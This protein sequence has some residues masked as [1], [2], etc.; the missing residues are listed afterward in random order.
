MWTRL[1]DGYAVEATQECHAVLRGMAFYEFED[2][3]LFSEENRMAF[4]KRSFSTRSFPFSCS[5]DLSFSCLETAASSTTFLTRG[6][7]R[8]V[9]PGYAG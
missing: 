9:N 6:K 5:S 2:F 3:R 1:S 8:L 7:S 4:F